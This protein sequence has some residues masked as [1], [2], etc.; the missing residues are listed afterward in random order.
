MLEWKEREIWGVE[1]VCN[2]VL[3]FGWEIQHFSMCY[4]EM[5]FD[6]GFSY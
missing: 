2:S 6:G 4:D 1:V 3:F 5:G